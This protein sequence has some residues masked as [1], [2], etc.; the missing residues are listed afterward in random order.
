[1]STTVETG[2]LAERLRQVHLPLCPQIRS[3]NTVW[4]AVEGYCVFDRGPGRLM[5]PSVEE[6]RNY[7]TTLKFH[8][9]PWFGGRR[10]GA[11]APITPRSR[12]RILKGNWLSP[13][14]REARET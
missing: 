8:Q 6:F 3:A 2:G 7:C 1:M 14:S 9:C 12:P 13:G 4:R 5:I 10:D 11:D